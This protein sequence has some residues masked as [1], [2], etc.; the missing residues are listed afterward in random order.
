MPGFFRNRNQRYRQ[1]NAAETLARFR[2][3]IEDRQLTR[4]TREEALLALIMSES[5]A[6]YDHLDRLLGHQ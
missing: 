1:V 5:N 2:G 4:N 3:I 6:A